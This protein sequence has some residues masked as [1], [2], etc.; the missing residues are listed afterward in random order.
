MIQWNKKVVY[1]CGLKP[2]VLLY[3]NG[4]LFNFCEISQQ[5]GYM[6]WQK[7]DSQWRQSQIITWEILYGRQ[8]FYTGPQKDVLCPV[9]C[10]SE[11][12]HLQEQGTVFCSYSE[13][14]IHLLQTIFFLVFLRN[15][16]AEFNGI[17]HKRMQFCLN[18]FQKSFRTCDNLNCH[19]NIY[20]QPHSV[21]YPI[22]I[23]MSNFHLQLSAVEG[24]T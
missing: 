18:R 14:H 7:M 9:C 19:C 23:I 5:L 8:C 22:S 6:A 16:T 24:L 2:N 11:N 10:A 15:L 1:W 21:Y 13:S 3:G 12:L 20:T 17:Y 4:S